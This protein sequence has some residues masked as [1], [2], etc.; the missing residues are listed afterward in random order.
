[1]KGAPSQSSRMDVIPEDDGLWDGA[2][3]GL[4]AVRRVCLRG[5]HFSVGLPKISSFIAS[6]AHL[7]SSYFQNCPT[8]RVVK[9][10]SITHATLMDKITTVSWYIRPRLFRLSMDCNVRHVGRRTSS[11]ASLLPST[12]PPKWRTWNPWPNKNDRD[13]IHSFDNIIQRQL[14]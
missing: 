11:N 9:S 1:M 10:N 13:N 4:A 6:F 3:L 12:T 7:P 2:L 14:I 8:N 5:A